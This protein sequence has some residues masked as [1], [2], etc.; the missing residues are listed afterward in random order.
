MKTLREFLMLIETIEEIIQLEDILIERGFP[1]ECYFTRYKTEEYALPT[2]VYINLDQKSA[3]HQCVYQAGIQTIDDLLNYWKN[4]LERP[5]PCVELQD[6][7]SG[8]YK[9][10]PDINKFFKKEKEFNENEI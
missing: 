4:Y 5:L 2:M 1:A 3:D 7:M 6:F 9:N 10:K 8:S